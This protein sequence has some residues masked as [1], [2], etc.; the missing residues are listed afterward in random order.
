MHINLKK[1]RGASFLTPLNAN[2]RLAHEHQK[3]FV[4]RI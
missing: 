3:L 4:T 2:T 1:P